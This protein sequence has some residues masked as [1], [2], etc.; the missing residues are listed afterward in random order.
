MFHTVAVMGVN[1]NISNPRH[2]GA[3]QGQNAQD[4]IVQVTKPV[5][6]VGQP[7]VRATA[8]H[9]NGP[10]ERLR[11][12]LCRQHN[13]TRPRG[14]SAVNLRKDRV[15]Q[16]AK[17]VPCARWLWQ[18]ARSLGQLQGRDIGRGVPGGQSG[19]FGA[20]AGAIAV[21]RQPSQ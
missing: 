5:G 10:A 18:I 8:R 6:P 19:G 12:Q 16:G 14:R 21:G 11:Q 9:M 4:R 15:G 7:M 1:I 2:A 3:L 17:I 20:R 13:P